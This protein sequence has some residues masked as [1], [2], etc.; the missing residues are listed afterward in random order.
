MLAQ[1]APRLFRLRGGVV[2]LAARLVLRYPC[3]GWL[4]DVVVEHADRLLTEWDK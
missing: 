1:T 3:P 2:R 4:S